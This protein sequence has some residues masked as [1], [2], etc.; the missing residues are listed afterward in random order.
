MGRKLVPGLPVTREGP[1]YYRT[2]SDRGAVP[3]VRFMRAKDRPSGVATWVA[4][5]RDQGDV[6]REA[7]SGFASLHEA[8]L[9]VRE[10][11][12]EG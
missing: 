5:L 10:H 9:W 4:L 6:A 11:W 12:M 1:G 2:V 7:A 3:D 8:M